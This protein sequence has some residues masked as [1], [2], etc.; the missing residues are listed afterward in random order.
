MSLYKYFKVSRRKK[1]G[2]T[3]SSS[4]SL[5]DPFGLL[6]EKML[7]TS[8]EKA[9]KDNM[10][11][12]GKHRGQYVIVTPDQ[13][14]RVAKYAAGNGT[15]NATGNGTINTTHRFAIDY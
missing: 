1:D 9:N 7:A 11:T 3:S 2:S 12:G 15:I 10:S 13:K 4:S 8:I 14:A 5:P 6:S